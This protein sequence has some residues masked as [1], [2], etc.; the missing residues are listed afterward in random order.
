MQS[1]P[2]FKQG[3]RC[4]PKKAPRAIGPISAFFSA[5]MVLVMPGP[6]V[7]ATTPECLLTLLQRQPQSSAT[8]CRQ[9]IT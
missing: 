3:R 1:S 5:V 2:T 6:A 4:A 8:S 9:S 7:T